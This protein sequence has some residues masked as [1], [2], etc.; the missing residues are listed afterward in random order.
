[1]NKD[2]ELEHELARRKVW[3][4]A[5][6]RTAG[7]LNCT[8]GLQASNWADTIL[9]RF[10][11]K[12]RKLYNPEKKDYAT[13]NLAS[14]KLGDLLQANKAVSILRGKVKDWVTT[15][16]ANGNPFRNEQAPDWDDY[17]SAISERD[18]LRQKHG[19]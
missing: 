12:F 9:D 11:S 7:A 1:M 18:R 16:N 13:E 10:D 5:A 19:V 4:D 6:S 3:S 14:A 15:E 2:Y 17:E 8:A